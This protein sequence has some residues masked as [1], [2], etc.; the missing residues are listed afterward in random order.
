LVEGYRTAIRRNKPSAPLKWLFDNNLIFGPVL[1][2][3]CGRGDDS[4]FLLGEGV[5]VCAYDPYWKPDK[6]SGKFRTV[7]CTYVLNVVSKAQESQV[8]KELEAYVSEGGGRLYLCEERF[9][10]R[11]QNAKI[12]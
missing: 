6:P 9:V 3:G 10:C 11:F 12:C 7:L 8:I 5:D 2:F 4:E 1:D